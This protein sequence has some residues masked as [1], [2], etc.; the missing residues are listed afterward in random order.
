MKNCASCIYADS[1]EE[2]GRAW[3]CTRNNQVIKHPHLQGGPNKCE[4][5]QGYEDKKE[6]KFSYPRRDDD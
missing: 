1:P 5:Y 2:D 6:E 4:C 3:R